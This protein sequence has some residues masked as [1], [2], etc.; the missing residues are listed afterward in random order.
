MQILFPKRRES[1]AG[2]LA[3]ASV[4]ALAAGWLL[5]I[6]RVYKMGLTPDGLCYLSM[7]K[8]IV[9]GSGVSIRSSPVNDAPLAVTSYSPFLSFLLAIPAYFKADMQSATWVLNGVLFALTVFL[10]A[11]LVYSGT[12]SVFCALFAE[13]LLILDP[14]WFSS[15]TYVLSEPLFICLVTL[16]I[17]CL[18][19][20]LKNETWS[21]LFL[22]AFFAGLTALTRTLGVSYVVAGTLC[23]F[24]FSRCGWRERIF[25]GAAMGFLSS[26]FVGLWGLRNYRHG[27]YFFG[28]NFSKHLQWTSPRQYADI[29]VSDILHYPQNAGMLKSPGAF[30]VLLALLVVGVIFSVLKCQKRS[31]TENRLPFVFFI[32]IL[33][34]SVFLILAL[35]SQRT[36]GD[37]EKFR[38]IAPIYGFFWCLFSLG[39]SRVHERLTLFNKTLGRSFACIFFVC[40]VLW[41]VP[42]AQHKILWAQGILQ[43]GV[44]YAKGE[45]WWYYKHFSFLGARSRMI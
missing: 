16:E 39:V 22:A 40:A 44:D 37:P 10:S 38:Y 1:S 41:L 28:K 26:V 4:A 5:Y 31:E 25:K 35:D 27:G 19:G 34:Y 2:Y 30:Y 32:F 21:S 33:S 12:G 24:L 36:N 9:E 7:A 6:T 42:V 13:S 11:C 20:Y 8:G 29:V 23:V 45:R 18:R 43:N 3:L 15:F 17:Y 14:P